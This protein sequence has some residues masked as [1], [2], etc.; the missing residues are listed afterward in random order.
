MQANLNGEELPPVP[1]QDKATDFREAEL[2][3][4]V[5]QSTTRPD[6]DTV[7]PETGYGPVRPRRRIL[8]KDGPMALYRPGRMADEDFQEM[9]QEIVPELVNRIIQDSPQQAKAEPSSEPPAD[10][11][12]LKRS[13]EDLPES[14]QPSTKKPTTG[15]CGAWD[16]LMKRVQDVE[17]I[18]L[19]LKWEGSPSGTMT[20][21]CKRLREEKKSTGPE[22]ASYVASSV[23]ATMPIPMPVSPEQAQSPY[24]QGNLPPGVTSISQWGSSLVAFG[25]YKGVKTYEEMRDPNDPDLASYRSYCV[26]HYKTGSPGLKDLVDYLNACGARAVLKL[27]RGPSARVD[28]RSF[29]S[30]EV[31]FAATPEE[32]GFPHSWQCAKLSGLS[33]CERCSCFMHICVLVFIWSSTAN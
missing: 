25:K 12:G 10:P 33:V 11:H 30:K 7:D 18:S 17:D 3:Q 23:G 29:L 2:P 26:S 21:A 32:A 28:P 8:Q 9:M 14:S 15:K 24:P 20:D 1:V 6:P 22:M 27:L 31:T 19:D 13:A 5:D 16:A 4:P